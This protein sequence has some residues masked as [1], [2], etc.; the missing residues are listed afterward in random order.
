M[1]AAASGNVALMA[2]VA[3][4]ELFNYSLTEAQENAQRIAKGYQEWMG[5]IKERNE[6]G[7]YKY[8]KQAQS[9]AEY[10]S[11]VEQARMLQN[12]WNLREKAQEEVDKNLKL[13]KKDGETYGAD[14]KQSVENLKRLDAA[15]AVLEAGMKKTN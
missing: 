8:N 7:W 10:G 1:A 14:F 11:N 4:M 12:L 15:V 9:V 6:Y 3:V 2:M 13:S 5:R